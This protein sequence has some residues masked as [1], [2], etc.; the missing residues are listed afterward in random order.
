MTLRRVRDENGSLPMVL[1][2]AIVIGGILVVVYATVQSGSETARRDRDYQ[3]AIQ[4][5]D[6]GLQEAF[7]MLE[8]LE[9]D[10]DP[11]CDTNADGTCSG[12]LRDGSTFV[13]EYERLADRRWRVRSAGTHGGSTRYVEASVGETPLFDLAMIT[14]QFFTYNGGGSETDPFAAGT[15]HDATLNGV[16]AMNS[17]AQLVLYGDGPHNVNVSPEQVPQT[18]DAYPPTLFNYAL[19]AF[20]EGGI[21]SENPVDGDGVSLDP[22]PYYSV[23]PADVSAQ[24]HTPH[25]YGNT[26]C[27]GKADFGGGTH[28][29]TGDPDA[30]PVVVIV[31]AHGSPAV[32]TSGNGRVNWSGSTTAADL[33]IYVAA[34]DVKV[35]GNSKIKAAIWAPASACTSD[36]GTDIAGAMVCN[37]AVLNGDFKFDPDVEE[38]TDEE[39]TISHWREEH[40]GTSSF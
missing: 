29:L 16:P 10:E 20:E 22:L 5:A 19:S 26:Y 32:R 36:G 11:P 31:D 28:T 34:G 3:Q 38:I 4:V 40:E 8:T 37:T 2:V 15:F 18:G 12:Q 6:A 14:K 13:W 39:F 33:Q 25:E 30:G 1:L 24:G 7:V 35:S 23:Y 17:T 27:V 9:E 21:C